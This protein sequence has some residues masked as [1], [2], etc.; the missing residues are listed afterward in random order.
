MC[1]EYSCKT[2]AVS[3][4]NAICSLVVNS[5]RTCR[6]LSGDSFAKIFGARSG[7]Y[8]RNTIILVCTKHSRLHFYHTPL[9][10]RFPI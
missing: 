10:V 9:M 5:T 6:E 8:L 1:V 2:T 3:G 4:P 7:L